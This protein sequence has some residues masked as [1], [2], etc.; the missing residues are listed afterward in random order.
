MAW[1]RLVKKKSRSI[2]GY[3]EHVEC[4]KALAVD[5]NGKVAE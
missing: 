4:V 1:A 5:V 3:L 2:F